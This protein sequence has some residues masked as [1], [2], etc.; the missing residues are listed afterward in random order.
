MYSCFGGSR[1]IPPTEIVIYKYNDSF[2]YEAQIKYH[3]VGRGNVHAPLD[4]KKFDF[5]EYDWIY[6]N[7]IKGRI[8]ADSLVFTSYQRKTKYPWSSSNLRGYM[9]FI[10]DTAVKL[11]FQFYGYDDSSKKETT[12][13]YRFNGTYKLIVKQDTVPLLEK[14]F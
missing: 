11:D 12:I 7:S 14:D 8:N 6:L 13:P 9:D 1:D 5:E 3:F 2:K 4:S 10:N